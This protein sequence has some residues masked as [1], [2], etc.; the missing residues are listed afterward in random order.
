M[1]TLNW[2][3]KDKVVNYAAKV[4]VHS[5]NHVY[6]HGGDT[7][8]KIIHGD[9]LCCTYRTWRENTDNLCARGYGT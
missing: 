7:G 8:N 2:I 4:P 9:N 1:P 3:G 6:N 5:L